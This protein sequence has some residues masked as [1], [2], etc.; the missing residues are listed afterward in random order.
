MVLKQLANMVSRG[1][2]AIRN[3]LPGHSISFD[4]K[5]QQSQSRLQTADAG[6]M[7]SEVMRG[8]VPATV[9]KSIGAAAGRIGKSDGLLPD[10]STR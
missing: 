3:R 4:R 10:I 9:E 5:K 7:S 2:P 6:L 1:S 8:A